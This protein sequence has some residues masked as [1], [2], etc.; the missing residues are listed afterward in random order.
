MTSEFFSPQAVEAYKVVGVP[1]LALVLVVFLENRWFIMHLGIL[2]S[3]TLAAVTW[4][5]V[6]LGVPF[7]LQFAKQN[8]DKSI[9]HLPEFIRSSN[10]ITSFWG[11][12]FTYNLLVNIL[13]HHFQWRSL[14]IE[15]NLYATIVIGITIT[16][17]YVHHAKK[18]RKHQQHP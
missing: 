6:L 1:L 11:I 3:T 12:V 16:L 9:W 10:I 7:T 18:K 17:I 8:V 5:S 13:A 15:I 2:A 4:G 14:Y